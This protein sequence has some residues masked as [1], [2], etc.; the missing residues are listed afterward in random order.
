MPA[1]PK[2]RRSY[3]GAPVS[4]ALGGSGV[5]SA[6]A[7]SVTLSSSP[8]T[9]PTGKFFV[10]VAPGTSSEEKMCVT[11]SGSTLTVVDPNVASTSAS[12]NGRGVDN[13]TARSSIAVG[14]V[15]YPVATAIDFD[16]ANSLTSTYA[17][18]GGI[19]YMGDPSFTQ[20]GIGTA[21]QVL[22]VNAGA[23]AP[24]W[25]QVATAGIADSAVT[26][27]KIADD[28]IMNT[29]INSAANIALSKLAT[30]ALPTAITIV[31]ANVDAAAGIVDT[32][33]ATIS[34]ANKVSVSSLDIDG[35]TDIGADLADA[36][37]I[38]VDDGANGTN[39]KSAVSRFAKFLFSK[40][41][42]DI[43]VT[44]A[45]VA[46]IG[47]GVIV[48]ADIAN[49]AVIAFSKLETAVSGAWST[50][51]PTITGI[52]VSSSTARY[53][54]LG[55]TVHFYL[56]L[57]CNATGVSSSSHSVTMP[58]TAKNQN[59]LQ[60][61]PGV[62]TDLTAARYQIQ[63]LALTTSTI[64]F[65]YESLG[66]LVSVDATSPFDS[67]TNDLITISGTYEAA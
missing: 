40:V 26:S 28:T 27:A 42:G 63:S 5:T 38:V 23:T 43:T 62:M 8:S 21:A 19:V 6:T 65:V 67:S 2:I 30:G 25:G 17:N 49:G 9:W 37:L 24:E 4:A 35:A 29:D 41:S 60:G 44:D 1:T 34:T 59:H 16:E 48:N 66:T 57:V 36:D 51:T 61:I 31:N 3:R 33:L 20:L 46:A 55:K 15:V 39:R 7:T 10:V 50:W 22:R 32:K 12:V 52:G 14:S 56:E 64:G 53:M 13:T 18:Q 47:S 11:L 54:Q 58:V 45:G